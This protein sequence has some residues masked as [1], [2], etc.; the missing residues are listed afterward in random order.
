MAEKEELIQKREGPLCT[1]V[2]NRPE[3]RN[4]VTVDCLLALTRTFEELAGDPD[5]RCVILTGAGE[6]AFCAG[7]DIGALPTEV[8]PD[9]EARL[10]ETPPL[11][12]ALQ[13]MRAY[14]YP[15]VGMLNG[16]AF[17]GG[18]ELAIGCDIRVA[19]RRVKM[20]VPPAKL[21]IVYPYDGYRRFL[22]VLGFAATLEIFLTGRRYDSSECLRRGMVN[23]VVE[24][25]Q[26][27]SFT[28]DLAREMAENA[29]LSMRG[30]KLALYKIADYPELRPE[31][32]EMIR[33]LFTQSLQSEDLKE[34]KK[35]FR[36]KR[37]PRFTGR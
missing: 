7:F 10:K 9:L 16:Y 13:A 35:A 28:Y 8:P 33:A 34:G 30:T 6:Q 37:K 2:I 4:M 32:E 15:V 29:P 18:C 31:D 20:G 17:G 23:Y 21:G 22:R 1:L 5:I 19:A 14:P 26:L 3:K 36:E 25:D 11:E 24:D 27:E 12:M